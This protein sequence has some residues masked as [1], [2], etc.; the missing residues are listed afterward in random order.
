[1]LTTYGIIIRVCRTGFY[2][3]GRTVRASVQDS[4]PDLNPY[5]FGPSRFGS[6]S[7]I[8]MYGFGSGSY[9]EKPLFLLFCDFFMTFYLRRMMEMYLQK[10]ESIKT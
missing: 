4:E 2:Q 5:V 10:V 8:Y 3:K 7:V 9:E 6:G 1:M